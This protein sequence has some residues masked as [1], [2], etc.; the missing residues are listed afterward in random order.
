MQPVSRYLVPDDR[1]F[2]AIY[3]RLPGPVSVPFR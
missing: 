2:M 1:D 3:R